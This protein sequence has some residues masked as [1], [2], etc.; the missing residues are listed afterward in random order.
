MSR[1]LIASVDRFG[2]LSPS[3][4]ARL[5]ACSQEVTRVQPG[6]VIFE[7]GARSHLRLLARGVAVKQKILQDGGR[8]IFGFATP[9]DLIDLSGLFVGADHEVRALGP[10]EVRNTSA[11]ELR[12]MVK[13]HPD[14]L[15]ALCRAVLTEA[16]SHRNW[17]V[18]LG[19]RSAKSRTAN[20][21][22]EIF[23][24]QKTLRLANASKCEFPAVQLDIADALGLS[25]VHIHRILRSLRAEGLARLRNGVLEIYDWDK[26]AIV[27]GFEPE[28]LRPQQD[29][30]EAAPITTWLPQDRTRETE[31]R[32]TRAALA[33][34]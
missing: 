4:R 20:L 16:H 31:E 30:G 6:Q 18:G 33:H 32:A 9:G 26:L 5:L 34:S 25:V 19:R 8:Q 10:C 7:Q 13:D 27:G 12:A 28:E 24:R 1:L 14:L 22:C 11:V 21:L 17:I 15:G 2:P 29:A 23:W 3:A